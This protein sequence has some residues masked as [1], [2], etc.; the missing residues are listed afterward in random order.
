M[1]PATI[2]E[3]GQ[4]RLPP[5][6]KPESLPAPTEAPP[7]RGS[8]VREPA[9]TFASGRGFMAAESAPPPRGDTPEPSSP[10][11]QTGAESGKPRRTGWWA[12]RIMGEKG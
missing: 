4:P 12:R 1:E 9:P 3:P 5:A 8:T 10:P 2:M 11:E 6:Q 7:K